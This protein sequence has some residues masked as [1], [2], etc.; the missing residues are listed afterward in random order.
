MIQDVT[1]FQPLSGLQERK[2]FETRATASERDFHPRWMSLVEAP[3]LEQRRRSEQRV[4]SPV[5]HPSPRVEDVTCG[6]STSDALCD[7]CDAVPR[8]TLGNQ[9]R[10]HML[11]DVTY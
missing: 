3:S 1:I 5:R 8:V 7:T 6:D 4:A 11:E 9:W 10:S 2:P